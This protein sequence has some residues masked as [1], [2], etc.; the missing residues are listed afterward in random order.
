LKGSDNM[1]KLNNME[2]VNSEENEKSPLTSFEMDLEKAKELKPI[3]NP[4]SIIGPWFFVHK[5]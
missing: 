4:D 3:E 2:K 5:V 1:K